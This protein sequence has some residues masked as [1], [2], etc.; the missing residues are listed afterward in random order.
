VQMTYYE[1]NLPHWQPD[2]TEIFLTWRLQGSLPSE[3][4][5]H[6]RNSK[7]LSGQQFARAESCLDR[8][9][10]GPRWLDQPEVASLVKDSIHRGAAELGQ[11]DLVSWV[12]MPNHVHLLIRPRLPL[13]KITGGM[14][15]ATAY[16][17]NKLLGH[18]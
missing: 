2:A 9:S 18:V 4:V 1:R 7:G 17:A 5:R 13:A 11:Y 12:I 16:Y 3:L 14:K 6:L 10:S 15:G 8:A